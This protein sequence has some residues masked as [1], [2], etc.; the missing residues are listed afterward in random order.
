MMPVLENLLAKKGGTFVDIGVNI[1]QTLIKA[2]CVQPN[3]DYIGFE[4]N[5]I[6]VFYSMELAKKNN[7]KNCNIVSVGVS[8]HDQVVELKFFQANVVDTCATIVENL[9]P[10]MEITQRHLVPVFSLESLRG[11]IKTDQISVIKIDVEGAELE[12]IESL[13]TIILESRPTILIE[14]LPVYSL[15]NKMRKERQDRFESIMSDLDYVVVR[16]LK[17]ADGSLNRL[18][19][20]EQIGIHSNLRLCDYIFHPRESNHL[21]DSSR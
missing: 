14:I 13:R 17:N 10:N 1:G 16:V 12:I 5:P 15:E 9:R 19:T 2:E 8:N 20:I 4:P 11:L 21:F 7:F 6:C 3:L 18:Q